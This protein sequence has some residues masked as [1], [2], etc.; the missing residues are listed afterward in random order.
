[1]GIEN[2]SNDEVRLFAEEFHQ[3][4]A[5][6][7][8]SV[9]AENGKVIFQTR[10][11]DSLN[12]GSASGEPQAVFFGARPIA[13]SFQT[14]EPLSNDMTIYMASAL[15]GGVAHNEF[16]QRTVFVLLIL[17]TIGALSAGVFAYRIAKPM[18]ESVH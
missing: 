12:L 10:S 18:Q 4:N 14:T 1:M 8:F 15:S 3:R 5:S 13:N 11:A 9:I 7:E 2:K 16:L 17:F 6:V